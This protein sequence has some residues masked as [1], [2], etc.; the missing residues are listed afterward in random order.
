MKKIIRLK[1]SDIQRVQTRYSSDEEETPVETKLLD[2]NIKVGNEISYNGKT[3]IVKIIGKR[4]I[5]LED[6]TRIFMKNK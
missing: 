4:I 2:Y 3:G 6:G 1:E 5:I